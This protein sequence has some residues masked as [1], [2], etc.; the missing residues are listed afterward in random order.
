MSFFRIALVAAAALATSGTAQA[1]VIAFSA[2]AT[3]AADSALTT[4][5]LNTDFK[6]TLDIPKFDTN[7]GTLNSVSFELAGSEVALIQLE[8]LS[9]SDRTLIGTA[10]VSVVLTASDGTTKLAQALPT[11]TKL[12]FLAAFDGTYDGTPDYS[13]ISGA[14][15]SDI[16]A[17]DTSGLQLFTDPTVLSLYSAT[18]GGLAASTVSGLNTSTTSS[19]NANTSITSSATGTVFVEYDYTTVDSAPTGVPEPA[20]MAL[21]GA[22]LTGLG[23]MRRRKA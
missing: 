19:G 3:S 14:T 21:L 11:T 13:G 15:Y 22:G 20:S 1:A 12:A 16:T 7:L 8:N 17:N 10:Q 18:G 5:S 2:G 23:L 9:N 4:G 6:V